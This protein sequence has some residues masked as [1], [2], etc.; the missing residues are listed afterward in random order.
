MA[1]AKLIAGLLAAGLFTAGNAQALVISIEDE[2]VYNSSVAGATTIDFSGLD[3]SAGECGYVSCD[4]S[5]EIVQGTTS[6]YAAP[7]DLGADN[8]YMTVPKA[9]GSSS[10]VVL[11][12]GGFFNYFGMFWGSIDDYNEISFLN[13]KTG[14]SISVDYLLLTEEDGSIPVQGGQF[15]LSDNRYV[16][17]FFGAESFDSIKLSSS[18]MAFETDNHAFATVP[19]PGTLAL[20]GLGLAGLG[21]SRRKR[22]A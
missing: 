15:D 14:T 19:E 21:L 20:F 16:N 8:P 3:L 10:S 4:G 17:F 1:I 11:D 2:G 13:S 6:N 7:F 9:G 22:L 12:P 5:Y 18:Q